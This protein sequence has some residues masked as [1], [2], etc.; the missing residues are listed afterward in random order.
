ML[1]VF[2]LKIVAMIT[3]L[4]D[5]IGGHL[6]NNP[7]AFRI[8]GRVAFVIYAFLITEGMRHTSSKPK[9]ILKLLI[10]ALISE[11]PFNLQGHGVMIY[12][13]SRNVVFTLLIGAL[14]IWAYE[15]ISDIKQTEKYRLDIA[16]MLTLV[17]MIIAEAINTDYSFAGVA[18]IM[19]FYFWN[20]QGKYSGVWLFVILAVFTLLCMFMAVDDI[21]FAKV[22]KAFYEYRLWVYF[23]V[24]LAFPFLLYYDGKKGYSSK[25]FQWIS[26][27]WYPL[28]MLAVYFASML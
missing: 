27:G 16:V 28:H 20:R 14:T 6:L 17:G 24:F 21:S 12:M 13:E 19:M 18:L 8:V 23:G 22:F 9:Y 25:V 3:M 15:V 7:P 26:W 1:S 11:I 2:I 10:L 4:I 5:H